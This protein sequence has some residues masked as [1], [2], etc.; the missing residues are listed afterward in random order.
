MTSTHELYAK[1]QQIRR[2]LLDMVFRAKAG[3]TGSSLSN[4]DILVTLYY[5]VMRN[6]PKDPGWPDR[7]R[8]V[9]SK[10][11][12]VESLYCILAD[13]GFFALDELQTF[14]QF[15][16]RL[17]G[18]PNNKVPGI[19]VNTGALG[20]GLAMGVGM[21]KAL[22]MDNASSR[23]FVLLGDGELA[24]GS[25]WEAAMAAAHFRLANL[26][27]IVDRNRLQITGDTEAV[28]AVEPLTEKWYSFGWQTVEIDGHDHG[29]LL[30]VLA[31]DAEAA[32]PRVVIAHTTKGRGV[33]YMENDPHWHHG[34]PDAE[35][36]RQ[37]CLEIEQEMENHG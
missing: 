23:V 7:D 32:Q 18:H 37:A 35:Q 33:S 25:V 1:A 5:A 27:A 16:S 14:C 8:F 17:I 21:A 10:G 31:A 19:E 6:D 29:Q 15:G 26:T 9:L 12:G 28:M 24:E 2:L 11:H 30:D 3:H 22:Q 13:R 34:V 36:F 4:T 20:H